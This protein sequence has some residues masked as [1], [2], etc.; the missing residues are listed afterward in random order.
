M[1][2]P[3]ESALNLLQDFGFFSVILPMILVFAI[4]YAILEKTK[5][6][7][8]VDN[9]QALNSIIAFVAAFFVISST[10]V[11]EAINNILPSASLLLIISMLLLMLLAFFGLKTEDQFSGE[12]SWAGK[13]GAVLLILVF[14]GMID[15]ATGIQIPII[16]QLTMAMVGRGA[17]A[18]I[19]AGMAI[20]QETINMIISF[21]LIF[22][23]PVI[24][25][26]LIMWK[27]G[28]KD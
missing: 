14:L 28:K 12:V 5:I 9:H 8:Q 27:G 22:G 16:H 17:E 4:F 2:N 20:S 18:G 10:P 13:I 11:V 24:V 21:A 15:L 1:I 25:L 7:D 6:F 19:G 3:F 26:L 23:I